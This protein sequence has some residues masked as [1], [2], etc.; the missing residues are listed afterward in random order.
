MEIAIIV[1]LSIV[2]VAIVVLIIVLSTKKHPEVDSK[3]LAANREQNIINSVSSVKESI[4]L[5]VKNAILNEMVQINKDVQSSS[6][7]NQKALFEFQ[8]KIERK[9]DEK[10]DSLN[11]KVDTNLND[12]KEKVDKSLIDGF[13]G[14]GDSMAQLQKA[15]GEMSHAQENIKALSGEVISL[16]SVLSN[17]QGRGRFGEIQLEML[18]A[19]MF[20][21]PNKGVLYDVQYKL[22]DQLKPDAVVFMDGEANGD[23]ILCIDSKFAIHGYDSLFDNSSEL[24]REE[25]DVMKKNFK[26]A[27]KSQIDEVSKY[28]I[29]GKT[30]N[31]AI[32][33]IPNDGIF[34]FVE[35][36]YPD[37]S[38]YARRQSV[39]MTCPTIIQP[40]IA[41]LRV[42]QN[43]SK[44][45]KNLMK[46]NDALAALGKE[47]KRFADRW[48]SLEK[49]ISSLSSK[50]NYFNTTVKKLDDKFKKISGGVIERIDFDENGNDV[51]ENNEK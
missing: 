36:E 14:T 51:V 18:L 38:E 10:I 17:N 30:L 42:I 12:I 22:T 5:L 50:S 37:L 45:N 28:V 24:T 3:E 23:A 4:P 2:L 8:E 39:V 13:K 33:F 1:L 48:D 20:G 34:A 6:E 32:M 31:T 43:D 21:E 9:L 27:L 16:K 25:K 49:T 15:L 35:N 41:A 19:S 40:L 26:N 46:I 44:K 11:K 29:D 7:K 47:F